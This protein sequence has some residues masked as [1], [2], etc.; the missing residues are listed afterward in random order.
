MDDLDLK[1]KLA[2]RRNEEMLERSDILLSGI[3]IQKKQV[4]ALLQKLNAMGV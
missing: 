4:E 3:D 2:E 1:Q